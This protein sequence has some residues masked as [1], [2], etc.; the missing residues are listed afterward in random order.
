MGWFWLLSSIVCEVFGTTFLKMA[1]N[2]GKNA[3][4]Y[5][6]IVVVSYMAC[7]ALLAF[8]M[9][10][11]SLSTVYATWSGIGVSLLAII[12][13]V[14]FGDSVNALKLVSLLL[15]VAGIIGLNMSGMSH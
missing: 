3:G 11:F 8:A 9:K 2:G 4:W 10:H 15:I 12:G 6:A 7:F 13:V 5:S 1:S 14:V